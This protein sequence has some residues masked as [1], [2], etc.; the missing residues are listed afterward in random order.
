MHFGHKLTISQHFKVRL[1]DENMNKSALFRLYIFIKGL[2]GSRIIF[3]L[4]THYKCINK[5]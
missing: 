1:P 2:P 4:N 5:F 3:F